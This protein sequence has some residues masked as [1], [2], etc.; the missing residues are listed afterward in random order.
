[1]SSPPIADFDSASGMLR[2]SARYLRG[3]DFPRLGMTPTLEPL[4]Q[5]AAAAVNLLPQ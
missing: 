1:M 4:A 5:I 2:A 3:K